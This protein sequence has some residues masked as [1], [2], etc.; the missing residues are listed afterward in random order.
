MIHD[1]EDKDIVAGCPAKSIKDKITIS[2]DKLFLMGGQ[3]NK[4]EEYIKLQGHR[5]KK[6]SFIVKQ[7][8]LTIVGLISAT[9][10]VS[11]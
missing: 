1:V 2:E 7:W 8:G 11:L 4:E 5:Y 6:K 3:N 10:L 9:P